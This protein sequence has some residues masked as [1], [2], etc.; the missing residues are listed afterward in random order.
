[1]HAGFFF[2]VR[3][4]SEPMLLQS[5]LDLFGCIIGQAIDWVQLVARTDL[6]VATDVSSELVVEID[7]A[8]WG[9]EPAAESRLNDSL[10]F[11]F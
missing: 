5:T 7:K 1:M 11:P 8:R 10:R 4:S 3:V 6:L 2:N 9:L